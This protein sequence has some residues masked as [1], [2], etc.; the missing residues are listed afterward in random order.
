MPTT[1]AAAFRE[2]RSNLEITG[3]QRET[4]STRQQ[5]VRAAVERG[6]TLVEPHSFL[7]GSYMRSTMTAPLSSADVDIFVIV[8]PAYFSTHTPRQLLE[9]LR[10]ALRETYPRT[11]A[12]RPDE[13]AVTIRFDDFTVDV[14]PA[15]HRK[16]GGYLIPDAQAGAWISTDP[17]VHTQVMA[18]SNTTHDG[19]LV[20]VVKMLKGWNKVSGGGLSGLYL[21]FM[22]RE[23]LTNVTISDDPSA[24]RFVLEK[25]VE[26]VKKK[27][28]D[29]AGFENQF[30]PLKT[31]T[32][33]TAVKRFS[34]ALTAARAAEQAERE[35]RTRQAFEHWKT[36]FGSYFPSYG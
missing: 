7:T 18:A 5:N 20:P 29:P 11:P 4:V 24:V 17:T 33:D 9:A 12:I 31:I 3:L 10:T 22:T 34:A 23:V 13:Q 1:I 28:R 16:G 15:F 32:L 30:N 19:A 21:E 27:V 8:S 26:R 35:G 25:G 14:V 6:L 2:L 36:V